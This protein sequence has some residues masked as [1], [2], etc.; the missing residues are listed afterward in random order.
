MHINWLNP[1]NLYKYIR[2]N[3]IIQGGGRVK[4]PYPTAVFASRRS[5]MNY[6]AI[7]APSLLNFKVCRWSFLVGGKPCPGD[8]KVGCTFELCPRNADN[9][10]R[11]REV[12]QNC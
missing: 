2:R 7:P 3:L 12:S 11:R 5:G 10:S 1:T 4:V 8:S 6:V 9:T